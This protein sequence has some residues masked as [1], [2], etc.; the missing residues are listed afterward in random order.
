MKKET[1]SQEILAESNLE[2]GKAFMIQ[3]SK[4]RNIIKT[5]SGLL[6]EILSEG[7]GIK[8]SSVNSTVTL[9]YRGSLIDGTTFTSNKNQSDPGTFT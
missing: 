9:N 7:D 8:P 4:E 3:K 6:Y 1:T 5:K 2:A